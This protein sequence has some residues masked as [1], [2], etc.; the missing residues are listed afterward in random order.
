MK[1]I[2]SILLVFVVV[3][4]LVA[5]KDE[6][7][8]VEQPEETVFDGWE[9]KPPSTIP[10]EEKVEYAYNTASMQA[11]DN[12]DSWVFE[13]QSN[14]NQIIYADAV[15]YNSAIYDGDKLYY[16]DYINWSQKKIS[17][18]VDDNAIIKYFD[19]NVI[20]LQTENGDMKSY[21]ILDLN[22]EEKTAN[23]KQIVF[24]VDFNDLLDIKYDRETS[25]LSYYYIDG[26]LVYFRTYNTKTNQYTNPEQV[27]GRFDDGYEIS[28]SWIKYEHK[29]NSWFI[30][31]ENGIV[32]KLHSMDFTHNNNCLYVKVNPKVMYNVDN[33]FLRWG[34]KSI[35][36]VSDYD[37]TLWIYD[38][39][40][41]RERDWQDFAIKINLPEGV[42]V[43][44]IAHID[45][46]DYDFFVLTNDGNAYMAA[47]SDISS[48]VT[49]TLTKIS[50]GNDEFDS[51]IVFSFIEDLYPLVLMD[52]GVLYQ[53][54]G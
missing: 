13:Q 17:L 40:E 50:S 52:D 31:D 22:N 28:V 14:I 32:Y 38:Y 9:I 18:D 1:K 45:Y 29:M 35:V 21:C 51:H 10:I 3:F 47:W 15:L 16:L 27:I 36:S 44:D 20:V 37:S 34:T 5:C 12:E 24:G 11:I 8:V 49:Q 19:G 25:V 41:K 48:S 33:V 46:T 7:K 30:K 26:G 54:V 43:D 42:T 2:I 53:I 39:E 23:A 6:G 4:S